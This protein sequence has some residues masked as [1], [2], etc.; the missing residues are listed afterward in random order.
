[1][2]QLR[3]LLCVP[4]L[5][6]IISAP[7]FGQASTGTISGIVTD[8]NSASIAGALVRLRNEA[9]GD[10]RQTPTGNDGLYVFSQLPPGTYEISSESAGFRKSVQ[11]GA[12]LRVNQT[13]EVNFSLQIGE[14]TQIVDDLPPN[15]RPIVTR[16]LPGQDSTSSST[17]AVV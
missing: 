4:L 1:M 10:T 3:T 2:K 7:V 12:V 15:F 8:P 9:T 16:E 14:V 5:G 17:F 6:C 11:T 13:L